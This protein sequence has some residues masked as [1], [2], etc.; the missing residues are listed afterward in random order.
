MKKTKR[1]RGRVDARVAA[2]VI[3]VILAI[4]YLGLTASGLGLIGNGTGNYFCEVYV[5]GT[6]QRIQAASSV[7]YQFEGNPCHLFYMNG[8]VGTFNITLD[9]GVEA[10]VTLRDGI[11]LVPLGAPMYTY[12]LPSYYPPANFSKLWGALVAVNA[13][14]GNIMWEDRFNNNE[15]A[16]PLVINGIAYVGTGSDFVSNL[17]KQ[18]N[19]A[20]VNITTGKVVW[21]IT[22]TEQNMPTFAYYK[23]QI[24]R[25]P[26][27][28]YDT[29]E[30]YLDSF[31][32]KTGSLLWQVNVSGFAAMSSPALVGNTLYIGL[33]GVLYFPN[34][35]DSVVAVNLDTHKVVWQRIF[36]EL[37]ANK[38]THDAPPA[39]WDNVLVEGYGIVNS[40]SHRDPPNL[41]VNITLVGINITSGNIIWKLNEGVGRFPPRSMLAAMTAYNNIVYSDSA[42][43]GYLYA[44]NMTTGKLLWR[45]HTGPAEANPAIID[46]Y[47]VAV[48]QTGTVFLLRQDGTLY[49][50]IN[51]NMPMGWCGVSETAVIG[52]K[53]VFGGMNGKLIV[54]PVSALIAK[55]AASYAA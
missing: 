46:G 23:G 15:M 54:M 12:A 38:A 40:T 32:A 47:V 43:V 41:T 2:F 30:G 22:T 7:L 52:D 25:M 48:N 44:A 20:A 28:Y 55:P 49:K 24:I 10:P 13:M 8:S 29:P 37:G 31:D 45:F 6:V 3:A 34:R 18:N 9:G 21:N 42:T 26:G 53:V 33:N 17:T 16:Q 19:I 35:G 5:N 27:G 51:L 14:T 4:A 11:L 50:K 1:K 39:V 36:L